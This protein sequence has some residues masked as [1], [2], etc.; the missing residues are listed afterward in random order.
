M[1]I[2]L[3]LQGAQVLSLV[4]ELDPM[5]HNQDP[6]QKKKRHGLVESGWGFEP[7][8]LHLLAV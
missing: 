5:Y 3:P 1:R 2:H 6:A 8:L 4:G 7:W